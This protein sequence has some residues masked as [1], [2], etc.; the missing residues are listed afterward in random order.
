MPHPIGM[1]R[2]CGPR[3]DTSMRI[4][5]GDPLQQHKSHQ[6]LVQGT[7]EGVEPSTDGSKSVA[8]PSELT[9]GGKCA[10]SVGTRR[11]QPVGPAAC[12]PGPEPGPLQHH[13]SQTPRSGASPSRGNHAKSSAGLARRIPSIR[14]DFPAAMNA[15]NE[16]APSG[17]TPSGPREDPKGRQWADPS[18]MEI[19]SA[20]QR[21]QVFLCDADDAARLHGQ[22]LPRM[23]REVVL[24]LVIHGG[25]HFTLKNAGVNNF[26]IGQG[27]TWPWRPESCRRGAPRLP[28]EADAGT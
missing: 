26:L 18:K 17:D 4:T 6:V 13:P 7:S 25:A 14:R 15:R 21:G 24:K 11:G 12:Q 20:A 28:P 19:G 22:E 16:E 23:S 2:S 27:S 1:R 3:R 9:C 8:L 10:G 5:Q